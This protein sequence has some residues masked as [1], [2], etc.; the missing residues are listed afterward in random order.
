M[1]FSRPPGWPLGEFTEAHDLV[2]RLHRACELA[3]RLGPS[4]SSRE[5]RQV[6]GPDAVP[7]ACPP[8][9][10]PCPVCGSATHAQG[11]RCREEG[12]RPWV[13][14]PGPGRAG[15][16]S[17]TV[18]ARRSDFQKMLPAA[19]RPEPGA[20]GCGSGVLRAAATPDNTSRCSLRARTSDNTGAESPGARSALTLMLTCVLRSPAG[21]EPLTHTE[22]GAQAPT[23]SWSCV[24]TGSGSG[25]DLDS[26]PTL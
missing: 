25:S 5:S 4:V 10:A 26:N 16:H 11:R 21:A 24:A 15:V 3:A 18:A 12:A 8:R 1:I 13:A 17:V 22:A 2:A 9:G 6:F 14:G 20:T 7:C 19:G 23:A